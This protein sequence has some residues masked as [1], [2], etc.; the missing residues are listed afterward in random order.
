MSSL[1][2]IFLL[3]I[4]VVS[5]AA[6]AF[7]P[8]NYVPIGSLQAVTSSS[9][10]VP[11][12]GGCSPATAPVQ[13]M[14]LSKLPVTI[15]QHPVEH[16]A[17]SSSSSSSTED[18]KNAVVDLR[19]TLATNVDNMGMTAKTVVEEG[20]AKLCA[21][22]Q[23]ADAKV[24]KLESDLKTKIEMVASNVKAEEEQAL[25]D[26]A[27][28]L[29]AVVEDFEA[30]QNLT[31]TNVQSYLAKLRSF[32]RDVKLQMEKQDAA[33]TKAETL[34]QDFET[35][36]NM[37]K[38]ALQSSVSDLQLEMENL[39]QEAARMVE[40]FHSTVRAQVGDFDSTLKSKFYPF[41]DQVQT[42]VEEFVVYID[43][44][45]SR[46]EMKHRELTGIV[47]RYTRDVKLEFERLETK[48]DTLK[49]ETE[50]K[51][52]ALGKSVLSF[53]ED[54]TGK[55]GVEAFKSLLP[56]RGVVE[57]VHHYKTAQLKTLADM[58]KEAPLLVNEA[59]LLMKEGPA[60]IEQVETAEH[61]HHHPDLLP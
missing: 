42:Q 23:D 59:P 52:A 61:H 36:Q 17:V 34:V 16:A 38:T 3:L 8:T 57:S 58:M 56:S 25:G 60:S 20:V 43:G 54:S 35:R 9:S 5:A 31:K 2:Q 46:M 49:R 11:E 19:S 37:M 47:Q 26:V 55:L 14:R 40:T 45:Q 48:F 50:A 33:A 32:M 29:E 22:K 12:T 30:K 39:P 18:I 44:V 1:Q 53:K 10:L 24:Q 41:K 27:T 21:F 13:H 15:L 4:F 6:S 51:F 28:K 7:T